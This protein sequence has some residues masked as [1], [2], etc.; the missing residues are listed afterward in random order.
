MDDRSWVV[1]IIYIEKVTTMHTT[2]TRTPVTYKNNIP[3]DYKATRPWDWLPWL[4]EY[5]TTDWLQQPVKMLNPNSP[6]HWEDLVTPKYSNSPVTMLNSNSPVNI[7][8]LLH[9]WPEKRKQEHKFTSDREARQVQNQC[10]NKARQVP[11]QCKLMQE[12]CKNN[13]TISINKPQLKLTPSD[14][15]ATNN[16]LN[17]KVNWHLT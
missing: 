4:Q 12:Q 7:A 6:G 2:T 17:Y 9:L 16:N 3:R 15:E 5:K 11:N 1:I 8:T 14:R 10:K 13:A